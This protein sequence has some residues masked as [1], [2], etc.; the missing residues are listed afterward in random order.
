M[1]WKKM[2]KQGIKLALPQKVIIHIKKTIKKNNYFKEYKYDYERYINYS[3]TNGSDS[4]IK[5]IGEIIRYYHVIEK[6]L[7]MPETRLGFGNSTITRLC[8]LC[9]DYISK[10]GNNDIQLKHALSV[11]FE[12]KQYHNE[13][14]Y[15]LN[16]ELETAISDLKSIEPNI[17]PVTQKTVLKEEY[18]KYKLSS[19]P[20]FSNS[21][22]SI[23]NYSIEDIVEE[24]LIA[25]LEL[26]RNTPSACNRQPWRTYVFNNKDQINA[27]LKIQGGNRG[28]GHL[29]NKLILISG[30]LGGF[31]G[32]SERNQVYIDGGMYAMNLLYSLHY[33]EIATCILNC[34][35]DLEKDKKMR[36][37]CKIKDSE[38]F[39]AIIACGIAPES[40]KHALSLRYNLKTT[41]TTV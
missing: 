21:R 13:Q 23:R 22:S 29:T 17:K 19:F 38:V 39:I 12:Y 36:E 25:A 2:I 20:D 8:V 3:S 16:I 15:Q 26:V 37:L 18:F 31:F 33:Y 5:L 10:F 34:S 24:K 35:H 40:F 9:N 28:F 1:K 14:N 32:I 11:I 30:E 6:G 4:A 27:I 7:T 41:N